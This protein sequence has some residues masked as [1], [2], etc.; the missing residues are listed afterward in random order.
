MLLGLVLLAGGIALIVWGAEWFTDGA[1]RTAAVMAVSP[2]AVG[3]VVS[4]LEPENLTTGVIAALE[5]L[6]QIAL[7]TVIGSAVFLLTAALGVSLLLVPMAIRIPR[8]ASWAMLASAAAFALSI[9]DGDVT[10]VEGAGLLGLAV[11]LLIWLYRASPVF[12]QAE[13]DGKGETEGPA[14]SRVKAIGLL[15]AGVA[16]LLV[17][18]EGIVRG[19]TTLMSTV[20]LSE[21]FLGMAVVGMGESLEEAAR[22]VPAA[23]RGHPELAWGNV[24]GT[25]VILLGVNLGLVALVQPLV[26]DPLVVRLHAP[27]LVG[28][29]LLVGGALGV[30]KEL[31]RRMGSLLV[32]LYLVYLALNLRYLWA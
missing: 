10:R 15:A 14:P 5:R 6:P 17:G 8:A 16:A 2:F 26:A 21:T 11:G 3:L 32:V 31:G 27:Y 24:V 28:C 23:R 18:A 22:M 12:L 20:K 1:L 13:R 7:G 4:G 30:A 29:I 9:W 25:V 19:V